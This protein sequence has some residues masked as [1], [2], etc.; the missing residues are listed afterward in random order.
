MATEN[1][2][3]NILVNKERNIKDIL[4]KQPHDDGNSC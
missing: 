2:C 4:L 3:V 1:V